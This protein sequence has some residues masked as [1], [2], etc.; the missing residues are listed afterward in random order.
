[1]AAV[2]RLCGSCRLNT[3]GSKMGLIM[4]LRSETINRSSYDKCFQKVC[5]ASGLYALIYILIYD[6]QHVQ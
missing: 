6:S 2:R 3:K 1:M 5:G 4:R